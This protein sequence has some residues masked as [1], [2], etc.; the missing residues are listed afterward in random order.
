MVLRSKL[1]RKLLLLPVIGLAL[2]CG[3]TSGA[4]EGSSADEISASALRMNQFQVKATHNSYHKTR[5]LFPQ[6]TQK[7]TFKPLDVQLESQGVRSF[8]LDLHFDSGGKK[9]EVYHMNWDE[10]STCKKFTD[11]LSTLKNWSDK[12]PLHQPLIVL[13]EAKDDGNGV[14]R[15]AYVAALE[16]TISATWP[17]ERLVTPALVQGSMPSVR[18][19][20]VKNG[21]PTLESVRGR[22]MFV[23]TGDGELRKTYTHGGKDL[24]GRL[25][26][27]DGGTGAPYSAV[28]VLDD[29]KGQADQI[30]DAVR[31]GFIVRTRADA[32]MVEPRHRDYS[33]RDAALAGGA[34]LVSTDLPAKD[35]G[36]GDYVVEIPGG[37]PSRCNPLLTVPGCTADAIESRNG[38]R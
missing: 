34:Q 35:D 27:A 20:I 24:D 4:S 18:E 5:W 15:D 3:D 36:Y 29:P 22:A 31:A 2:A 7:Y 14:D 33:R 32:D 16:S 28:A 11:C 37:S 6:A 12:H 9:F 23:L 19:A 8:E 1:S 38:A 21:W 30:R 25:I 10:G 13:L 26:F 17:R